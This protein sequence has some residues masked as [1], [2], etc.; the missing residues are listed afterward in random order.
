MDCAGNSREYAEHQET[1]RVAACDWDDQD[2]GH[3]PLRADAACAAWHGIPGHLR[4]SQQKAGCQMCACELTLSTSPEMLCTDPI[5]K[6]LCCGQDKDHK[7]KHGYVLNVPT[8]D[9]E[10]RL[11]KGSKIFHRQIKNVLLN[12]CIIYTY[13]L[14]GFLSLKDDL[15]EFPFHKKRSF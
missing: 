14:F 2:W 4:T 10:N 13:T 7:C 11:L 9:L 8:N 15:Q 3:I 6:I 5:I 1:R 12:E